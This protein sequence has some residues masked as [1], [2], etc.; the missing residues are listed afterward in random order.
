LRLGWGHSA[1]VDL[2][3]GL[4]VFSSARRSRVSSETTMPAAN[5]SGIVTR[6]GFFSGNRASSL[7]STSTWMVGEM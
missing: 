3:L 5:A 2:P 1:E 7:P 6:A 4:D